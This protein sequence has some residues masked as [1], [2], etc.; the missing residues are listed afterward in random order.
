MQQWYSRLD[1]RDERRDIMTQSVTESMAIERV[2]SA[3][4]PIV[5]LRQLPP[6]ILENAEKMI[7]LLERGVPYHK[8]QIQS[9]LLA[10]QV[11]AIYDNV[12]G[13]RDRLETACTSFK[14][15]ARHL[16]LQKAVEQVIN[17]S[18][19]EVLDREG[20]V[21]ELYEDVPVQAQVALLSGLDKDFSKAGNQDGGAGSAP[22]VT[23]NFNLPQSVMVAIKTGNA[24]MVEQI[25]E[26]AK[27][28]QMER[29]KSAVVDVTPV[30]EQKE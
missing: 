3:E 19:K 15:Q 14:K 26:L 9:G 28:R 10:G 16:V 13:L 1:R 30:N 27:Q 4:T 17:G 2:D 5:A 29:K 7:A 20:Q 23:M 22:T 8:A 24:S 6:A 18:K 21:R 11:T 25:A 12:P